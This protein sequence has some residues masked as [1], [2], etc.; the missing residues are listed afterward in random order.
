M[1]CLT[2]PGSLSTSRPLQVLYGAATLLAA[3]VGVYKH[4]WNYKS[5]K[6]LNVLVTPLEALTLLLKPQSL[7]GDKE[8][9]S[10]SLDVMG[11]AVRLS[12]IISKTLKLLSSIMI[13]VY[14]SASLRGF[15][16]VRTW[17]SN[18]GTLSVVADDPWYY[19]VITLVL[20]IL[21]SDNIC[22]IF[23][24]ADTL[25]EAYNNPK[26]GIRPTCVNDSSFTVLI[27]TL[28]I[29]V[30][31]ASIFIYVVHVMVSACLGK[32]R[33]PVRK[34]YCFYNVVASFFLSISAI[35]TGRLTLL[36]YS[37]SV[38]INLISNIESPSRMFTW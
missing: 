15:E 10:V 1:V 19:M 28:M 26:C 35:L 31:T 6:A 22:L 17:E 32:P 9:K 11:H 33:S 8:F 3:C 34:W 37:L 12:V 38:L 30:L 5:F 20:G 23:P 7:L 2:P 27:P 29:M 4:I 25:L 14:F 21:S 13:L 24:L 16:V 18:G 36:T